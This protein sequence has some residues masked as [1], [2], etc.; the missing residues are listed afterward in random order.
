[1][2]TAQVGSRAWLGQGQEMR[3]AEPQDRT[4]CCSLNSAAP[5]E[6]VHTYT[7]A[8]SSHT[9]AHPALTCSPVH[10]SHT[11]PAQPTSHLPYTPASTPAA[12]SSLHS[13]LHGHAHTYQHP[14]FTHSP[15]RQT[16]PT[17]CWLRAQ[18]LDSDQTVRD[19]RRLCAYQLGSTE[20]FPLLLFLSKDSSP[21]IFL[22]PAS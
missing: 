21:K 6:K 2:T 14:P 13:R 10:T 9:D 17:P 15:L 4:L 3:V 1:M 5:G 19:A 11:H 20:L 16:H 8:S 18:T 22:S 12:C 7:Q